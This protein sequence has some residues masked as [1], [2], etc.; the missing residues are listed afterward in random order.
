MNPTAALLEAC[1]R[2]L[3]PGVS[4]PP[5]HVGLLPGITR[6]RLLQLARADGVA[7]EEVELY[8]A[9][10]HAADELF[11]TSSI[12][13]V[14]PISRL[15]DRSLPVGPVTT[16]LVALYERFLADQAGRVAT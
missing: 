12:R 9:D 15:D 3:D 10:L 13:G 1:L 7:V 2:A 11:I 5:L 6:W 8:P 4:V 16:R 14:L